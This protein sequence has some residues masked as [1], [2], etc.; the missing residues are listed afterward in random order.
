MP[1]TASLRHVVLFALV[2]ACQLPAHAADTIPAHLAGVWGTAESLYTG[3]TA[4]SELHLSADGTGALA[5]SSPPLTHTAGP[6]KG[7]I[8]PRMRVILGVPVRGTVDGDVLTL[9]MVVKPG[10]N[11]PTPEEGRITCRFEA[12]GQVLNC[13]GT[14]P[15]GMGMKRLRDTVPAEMADMIRGAIAEAS[16]YAGKASALRPAPSTRP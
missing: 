1:A 13:S 11:G 12:R 15:A 7:K 4:Q 2:A 3:T 5:G 9:Q 8:E 10:E 6:D 14:K 16:G